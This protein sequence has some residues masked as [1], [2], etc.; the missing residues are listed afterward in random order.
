MGRKATT[1]GEQIDILER[2]GLII[3]DKEKA[4]EQ[5]LDIGYYR[6]GFYWYPFQLGGDQHKFQ[7]GTEWEN[8]IALY[9]FDSDLRHLLTNFLYRIEVNFRTKL[10]YNASNTYKDSPVWF[11]DKRYVSKSFINFLS[12]IYNDKFKRYN[13]PIKRHHAKYINDRYA[14]AWKTLEFFSFGQVFKLFQSLKDERL[15]KEIIEDYNVHNL[16][17]FENHFKSIINIRNCCSHSQVLFDYNQPK[18]IKRIPGE[19]YKIKGRN[20]TNLN[21]SLH[22]IYFYLD[23]ISKNRVK[24]LKTDLK[25]LM[26]KAE[27]LKPIAELTKQIIHEE[28]YR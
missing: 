11:A 2:R 27:K 20:R 26:E 16:E 3:H 15:K 18:G 13:Q 12:R 22:T 14:P 5:L 24:D 10:I 6:L 9:Y 17:V 7:K 25:D 1:V 28:L 23:K 21:A 4:K 19:L 8:I